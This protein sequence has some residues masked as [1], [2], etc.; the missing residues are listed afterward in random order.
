MKKVEP[1][2]MFGYNKLQAEVKDLKEVQRPAVVKA[3]EE[4]LEHGDLKENSGY[5]EGKTRLCHNRCGPPVRPFG[6]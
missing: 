6:R 4:A 2:T 5:H 1:M 3:I